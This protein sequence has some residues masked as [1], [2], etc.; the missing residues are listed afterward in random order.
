MG[1]TLQWTTPRDFLPEI[2]CVAKF[3]ATNRGFEASGQDPTPRAPRPMPQLGSLTGWRLGSDSM[4]SP[5]L[6]YE[7]AG[8]RRILL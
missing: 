7:K 6:Y 2:S 8:V 4:S 5:A 1:T 3:Q